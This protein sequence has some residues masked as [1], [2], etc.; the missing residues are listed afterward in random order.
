[1][2]PRNL[3]AIACRNADLVHLLAAPQSFG[4]ALAQ[5]LQPLSGQRRDRDYVATALGFS[6]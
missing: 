4:G 3:A 1:M 5:A 2:Q 6:E